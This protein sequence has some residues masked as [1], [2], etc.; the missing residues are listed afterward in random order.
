MKIE[1]IDEQLLAKKDQLDCVR[2]YMGKNGNYKMIEDLFYFYNEELLKKTQRSWRMPVSLGGLG[3]PY[4]SISDA[5]KAYANGII[6]GKYRNE[7]I[8]SP[9]YSQKESSKTYYKQLKKAFHPSQFNDICFLPSS[10]DFWNECH[11]DLLGTDLFNKCF[12]FP[13]EVTIIDDL[14][15]SYLEPDMED[16][17][18]YT[19]FLKDAR[20]SL[21]H[22]YLRKDRDWDSLGQNFQCG[23]W[24]INK[25]PRNE[26]FLNED[27]SLSTRTDIEKK[28]CASLV[29]CG[30]QAMSLVQA[31]GINYSCGRS[32]ER[33]ST[34]LNPQERS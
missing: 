29:S 16:R 4:G 1:E 8:A 10:G 34:A 13:N 6:C 27:T 21:S 30:K 20:D 12:P 25:Q 22:P 26:D 2:N 31:E 5:A 7:T 28:N 24:L 17:T 9:S 3:L 32:Y 23:G 19:R 33:M 15:P 14:I 11:F 18:E